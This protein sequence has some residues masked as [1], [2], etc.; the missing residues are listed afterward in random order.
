MIF[1]LIKCDMSTEC[2][3]ITFEFSL[4]YEIVDDR[5]IINRMN[6]VR[7]NIEY[8]SK[9]IPTK[10]LKLSLKNQLLDHL[11][12]GQNLYRYFNNKFIAI[13]APVGFITD[14]TYLL[15]N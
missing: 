10:L 2:S 14:P 6:I 12:I 3:D 8:L 11:I 4:P 9:V 13:Q 5:D 7:T 1:D 15:A